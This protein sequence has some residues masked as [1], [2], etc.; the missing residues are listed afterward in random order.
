M[1]FYQLHRKLSNALNRPSVA[2]SVW[3]VSIEQLKMLGLKLACSFKSVL[4]ERKT[5]PRDLNAILE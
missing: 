5:L 3:A 1:L 2:K 4:G